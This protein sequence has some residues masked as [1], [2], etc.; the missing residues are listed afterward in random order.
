[1]VKVKTLSPVRFGVGET[2]GLSLDQAAVRAAALEKLRKGV[3]Q[4]VAP[5]EFKAGETIRLDARTELSRYMQDRV[6]F[7]DGEPPAPADPPEQE[8]MTDADLRA[9]A[10]KVAEAQGLDTGVVPKLEDVNAMLAL[11]DSGIVLDQD[12]LTAVWNGADDS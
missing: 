9:L 12:R 7:V 8:P 10:Q 2:L 6:E 11:G 4:T 5:V 1:M 3:Y